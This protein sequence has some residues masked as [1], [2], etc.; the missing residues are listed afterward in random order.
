MKNVPNFP[1]AA[2]WLKKWEKLF[3]ELRY[4]NCF[5]VVSMANYGAYK[6]Y[7]RQKVEYRTNGEAYKM[8]SQSYSLSLESPKWISKK[9]ILSIL[10][11]KHQ[12]VLFGAN[13]HS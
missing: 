6:V 10:N 8:Y 5:Y 9:Q 12:L 13:Y 11:P 4:S 2:K 1:N 7:I 3:V